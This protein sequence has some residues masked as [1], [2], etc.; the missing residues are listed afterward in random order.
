MRVP[1]ATADEHEALLQFL[2]M[3]PVG[4][5]QT[6]PSGEISMANPTSAQLLMPLSRDGNLTN[7]FTALEGVA[8]DLRHRVAGYAQPSG[9][10]LDGLR[11]QLSPGV[12]GESDPQMM[13]LSLLKLDESRLMAVLT[14]ITQQVRRERQLRKSEAWFDAVLTG[15]IDYAMVSLDTHGHI[16]DWNAGVG[17][18]TGFTREA[19]LGRPFSLFYPDGAITPDQLKDRLHEA[20]DHGWSLDQGWCL[21]ADGSRFWGSAMIV[22]LLEHA[23]PDVA[24]QPPAGGGDDDFAYCLILRDITDKRPA[25]DARPGD[26]DRNGEIPHPPATNPTG[27]PRT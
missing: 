26:A 10:V 16:D 27:T 17:R 9:K 22:P 5:V 6:T 4:L 3:A 13:C 18:V 23:G 12:R 20:D 7:L 15:I 8:P 11:I 2:Y 14:D 19:S 25:G 24:R 1:A 21:R